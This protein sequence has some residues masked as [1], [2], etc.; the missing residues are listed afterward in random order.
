MNRKTKIWLIAATALVILGL[1]MFAGVMSAYSW[2]FDELGIERFGTSGVTTNEQ[3]RD[4]SIQTD[5]ADI[6]FLPAEDGVCKVICY[7]KESERHSVTVQDG[8]LTIRAEKKKWYENIG[9]SFDTPEITVY[10]PG[11]EYGK[12]LIKES[13]GDVEIPD[14]FRFESVDITTSTGDVETEASVAETLKIKTSTGDIQVKNVTADTLDLSVSTGH[15][16]VA[17]VTCEGDIQ[18]SVSTG[19][20]NITDLKCKN[21]LSYGDTGDLFLHN[22]VAG[23][24]F[25]IVRSTGDVN[26]VACDAGQ[27][28]VK[29]DTGDVTGSLLTDKIFL[30]QTDTGSVNVPKT[31]SGGKC[32]ITTD[33]G[34]IKLEIAK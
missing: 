1:V 14:V 23:E 12:L 28:L 31:T 15:I 26:F 11:R 18:T 24:S 20:T 17:N 19:K 7:E 32:E 3:I 34:D 25:S 16:T 4:I 8:V 27:I 33:T 30:A 2:D 5:T 9:I 13:T 29:T 10:L 21:L 22:V 6:V